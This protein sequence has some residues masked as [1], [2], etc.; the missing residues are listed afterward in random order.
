MWD[1][2]SISY[3]LGQSTSILILGESTAAASGFILSTIVPACIQVGVVSIL[4]QFRPG[5]ISFKVWGSFQWIISFD[6]DLGSS[7]SFLDV[8][9]LSEFRTLISC[10]KFV[11]ASCSLT[12]QQRQAQ[13]QLQAHGPL[14]IH[15]HNVGTFL[16]FKPTHFQD[17]AG[18]RL[19]QALH[20]LTP[21]GA[22]ICGSE[23]SVWPRRST[24]APSIFDSYF[25]DV[26][27]VQRRLSIATRHGKTK[28][29]WWM[30]MLTKYFG[31]A[32]C[33]ENPKFRYLISNDF[34]IF[35]LLGTLEMLWH[36]TFC[37]HPCCRPSFWATV[38]LIKSHHITSLF[39]AAG[40]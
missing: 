10:L 15:C 4:C 40:R 12:I 27:S 3:F 5:N 34:H 16:I 7:L 25:C 8:V 19:R 22:H 30:G 38:F 2:R 11:N 14:G 39:A 28:I 36:E 29:L 31:S 23:K 13:I 20:S 9:P 35:F 18:L 26:N 6:W 33:L 1:Y 24:L 21:N 17:Q 37:K 32:C